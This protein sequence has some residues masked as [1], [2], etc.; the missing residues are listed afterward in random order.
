MLGFFTTRAGAAVVAVI[1]AAL[2]LTFTHRFVYQAGR[3]VEQA[4]FL[5][6]IN[7]ENADA[8]K[9]AEKWRAEYRRCVDAGG[10]FNF[11]AG[12]CDR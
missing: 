10:L 9:S 4:A 11:E 1:A 5:E 6:R 3:Q 8:G 12:S 2:L 7:R